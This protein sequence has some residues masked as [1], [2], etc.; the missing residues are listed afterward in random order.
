[1][2]FSCLNLMVIRRGRWPYIPIII[3]LMVLLSALFPFQVFTDTCSTLPEGQV[4]SV[5]LNQNQEKC[6]K[7]HVP[8]GTTQLQFTLNDLTTDLD[9]YTKNTSLPTTGDFECRS[10]LNGTKNE[11]YTYPSPPGYC[12][13]LLRHPLTPNGRFFVQGLCTSP[14]FFLNITHVITSRR[15]T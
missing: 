9:L 14:V 5:I 8:A 12:Y 10:W 3:G 1:M 6:F 13:I 2:I 11:V 7:I 4:V 15:S